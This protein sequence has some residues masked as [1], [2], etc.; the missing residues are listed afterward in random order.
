MISTLYNAL[1]RRLFFT[2]DPETAHGLVIK[3]LSSGLRP[4]SCP[5]TDARLKQE[6]A[7]LN[8]P[9]PVGV[10]AG[11]D[12][13]AEVADAVLALGFGF[14]EIGTVTPRPQPGNPKPRVFRLADREALI[15]RLGFNN[16]G[17]AAALKRLEARDRKT[18]I[19]GVNIGANKNSEDF[20]ADYVLGIRKL[21]HV[22]DYFTV[23]I[24]SPNTP[25]LRNLQA[26]ET[27]QRLLDAV[28]EARETTEFKPPIFLKISPDLED[29]EIGDIA[30]V[31][32]KSSLAGMMISNTTLSRKGVERERHGAEAGGLSGRPLFHRSTVMLAR[33]RQRLPRE[34]PIVGIG[35]VCDGESAIAKLEAGASLVQLYTGMIYAGP[36]VAADICRS[37][38]ARMD[39]TGERSIS[40]ISATQTDAWAA[41]PLEL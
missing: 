39:Q 26:A 4:P 13:N 9:N 29:S 41:K 27:L 25:G 37:I 15:N 19:C 36:T 8:F 30:R 24:S 14:T 3:A 32:S 34:M 5:A 23:N 7:G 11:F 28:F 10:A 31:V 21:A 40:Q 1:G 38:I 2:L 16:Q 20:V 35:G 12:K 17:H 6:L 22:A 33:F 18:G